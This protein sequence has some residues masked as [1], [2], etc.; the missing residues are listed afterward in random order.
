MTPRPAADVRCPFCH[1]ALGDAA[2]RRCAACGARAHAGCALELA[3]CAACGVSAVVEC[4]D[5]WDA[6]PVRGAPGAVAAVRVTCD[7]QPALVDASGRAV[8]LALRLDL[9]RRRADRDGLLAGEAALLLP[10]G[11]SLGPL[12]L[13]LGGPRRGLFRRRVE[14]VVHLLGPERGREPWLPGAYRV[15]FRVA[16]RGL[17][18]AGDVD[19]TLTLERTR[20]HPVSATLAARV[21]A[22]LAV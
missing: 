6:R 3:R 12:R 7:T 13:V 14:R 11:L 18:V 5:G 16:A 1:D 10:R 21:E 9:L 22:D 17:G 19:V 20:G 8:P 15:A 4:V 2:S